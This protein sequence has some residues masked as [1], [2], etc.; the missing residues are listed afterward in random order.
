[1]GKILIVDDEHH[2][3]ELLYDSIVK[4]TDNEVDMA[5]SGEDGLELL[6]KKKYSLVFLDFKL[7]NMTGDETIK[8]AKKID[9]DLPIVIM[10]GVASYKDKQSCL[11]S[12][13]VEFISK[14]FTLNKML[15]SI[16]TYA[17]K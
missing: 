15:T 2:I 10:S 5:I 17:R 13:A 8:K 4:F 14:P 7:P 16:N 6:N 1:M 9:P 12:G 3:R 11:R